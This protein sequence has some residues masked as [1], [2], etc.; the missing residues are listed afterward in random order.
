MELGQAYIGDN[1]IILIVLSAIIL[2]LINIP[3]MV[4]ILIATNTNIYQNLT[5]LQRILTLYHRNFTQMQR[6][7]FALQCFRHPL[8]PLRRNLKP[9]RRPLTPLHRH[10]RLSVSLDTFSLPLN[11]Y[12]TS[13]FNSSPSTLTL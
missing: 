2:L 8:L 3:D 6:L 10:L 13:P 12:R 7:S 11:A 1:T 9:S 4:A 5:P